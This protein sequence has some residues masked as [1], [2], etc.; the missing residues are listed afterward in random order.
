MHTP[1]N[2]DHSNP[3]IGVLENGN[4][5]SIELNKE[6]VKE[7]KDREEKLTEKNGDQGLVDKDDHDQLAGD[8]VVEGE[9]PN[10][11]IVEAQSGPVERVVVDRMLLHEKVT[12]TAHPEGY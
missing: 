9:Q 11:E 7:L 3:I 10:E 6:P 5:R 8:L 4:S 2:V 12:E 1:C